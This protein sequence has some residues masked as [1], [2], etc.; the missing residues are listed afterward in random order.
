MNK[1]ES[2]SS[3]TS[4]YVNCCYVSEMAQANLI[5]MAAT[6]RRQSARRGEAGLSDNAKTVVE[7]KKL[8]LVVFKLCTNGKINIFGNKTVCKKLIDSEAPS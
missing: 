1:S 3:N 7:V 2:F 6:A 4:M 8:P 5:S